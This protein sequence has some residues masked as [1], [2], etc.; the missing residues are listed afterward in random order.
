MHQSALTEGIRLKFKSLCIYRWSFLTLV[1]EC[2]AG[3]NSCSVFKCL[4][5]FHHDL[6]HAAQFFKLLIIFRTWR[7]ET[8]RV[9]VLKNFFTVNKGKMGPS[10]RFHVV[11]SW[12]S[13]CKKWINCFVLYCWAEATN[14]GHCCL[15]HQ[16]LWVYC[17]FIS[18][19]CSAQ[20]IW[21]I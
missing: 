18:L 14:C 15:Y 1:R 20:P 13:T 7:R 21:V 10:F 9:L 5:V 2:K 4:T 8:K 17:F 3:C 11:E 6:A 16:I 12:I 19:S